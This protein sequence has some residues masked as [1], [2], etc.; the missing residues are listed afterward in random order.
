MF[1]KCSIT[2]RYV[3][4]MLR[5]ETSESEMH[6]SRLHSGINLVI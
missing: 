3:P 6:I 5:L 2:L 1:T 4:A